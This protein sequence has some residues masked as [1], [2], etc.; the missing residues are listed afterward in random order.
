ML[1]TDCLGH[2]VLGPAPIMIARPEGGILKIYT[3][4]MVEKSSGK[5][6]VIYR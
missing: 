3:N 4:A 2:T 1:E 6:S 5:R